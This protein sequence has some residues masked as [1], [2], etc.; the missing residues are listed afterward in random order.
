MKELMSWSTVLSLNK[1]QHSVTASC[2]VSCVYSL[3]IRKASVE[4]F[5]KG[6]AGL[7]MILGS[8]V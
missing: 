6:K 3:A 7:E 8:R 4:V 2:T 5:A 1:L